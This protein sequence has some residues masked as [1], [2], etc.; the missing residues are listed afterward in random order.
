MYA[1]NASITTKNLKARGDPVTSNKMELG[2]PPISKDKRCPHHS[3][4]SKNECNITDNH[5]LNINNNIIT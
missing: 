1:S 2:K 3:M 5:K 4:K